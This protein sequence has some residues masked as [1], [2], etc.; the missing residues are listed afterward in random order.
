M[1]GGWERGSREAEINRLW[2]EEGR[3]RVEVEMRKQKRERRV[4]EREERSRF[5]A[6]V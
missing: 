6:Y 5:S 2:W 3:G 4:E 1:R